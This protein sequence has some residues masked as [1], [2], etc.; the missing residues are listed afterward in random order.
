V[1]LPTRKDRKT[2][3]TKHWTRLH[4]HIARIRRFNERLAAHDD[5]EGF[6]APDKAGETALGKLPSG[7]EISGTNA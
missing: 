7:P 1:T 5:G 4:P 3:F 2:R 6:V